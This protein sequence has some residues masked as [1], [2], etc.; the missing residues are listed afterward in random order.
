MKS[1]CLMLGVL[2]LFAAVSSAEEALTP[3]SN[4]ALH[5]RLEVGVRPGHIVTG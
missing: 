1:V 3:E 5:F 4:N 2:C